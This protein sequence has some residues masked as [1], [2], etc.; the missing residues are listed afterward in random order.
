MLCL[1]FNIRSSEAYKY[2]RDSQLLPLP[3]TKTVRHLL[4]SLKTT[5]GFDKDFLSY[6]F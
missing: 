3:H 6:V 4:S 2:L 5:C 1:L